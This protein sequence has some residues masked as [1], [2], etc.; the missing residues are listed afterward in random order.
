MHDFFFLSYFLLSFFFFLSLFEQVS[1]DW[2]DGKK[3][4]HYYRDGNIQGLANSRSVFRAG[5]SLNI[6][7][8][9]HSFIHTFRANDTGGAGYTQLSGPPDSF[10][11]AIWC[12]E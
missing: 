1:S 6:H 2:M 7:S 4:I 9:I 8:F 5:V 12:W 3:P 11:M 10:P